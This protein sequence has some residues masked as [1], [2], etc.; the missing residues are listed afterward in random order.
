MDWVITDEVRIFV[1]IYIDNPIWRTLMIPIIDCA[2]RRF[3]KR[4]VRERRD[5]RKVGRLTDKIPVLYSKHHLEL[6]DNLCNHEQYTKHPLKGKGS[7]SLEQHK[8]HPQFHQHKIFHESCHNSSNK[9]K[10]S[11]L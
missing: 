3:L 5:G 8:V 10:E 4:V 1:Q 11:G 2:R 6:L 9:E 7:H